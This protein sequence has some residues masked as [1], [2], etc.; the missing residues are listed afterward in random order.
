MKLLLVDKDHDLIEMLAGWLKTLGYEVSYAYTGERA[1]IEWA[2]HQPDLVILDTTLKD[3]DALAMC[4][5]MRSRYDALLLVMTDGKDTQ[6]EIHS[7]ESG[8]D[9]YLRKPFSPAQFL[10]HVHA[11][12][13]RVNFMHVQRPSSTITIGPI[14]IDS[15]HNQVI[16]YDK[17]TRLTPTESKLLHLL[18][19]NAN[20]VCTASHIVSHVWGFNGAGDSALIKAHIRHLR[21]KIEP[22]PGNPCY[23]QTVPSLGYMLV[24]RAG[25]EHDAREVAQPLSAISV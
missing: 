13:R 10:A 6:D 19:V 17:T 15:L 12:S 18:A 5:E 25:E 22:D 7:L 24:P 23:I 1:K 20:Q 8:A 4:R 9:D 3:V 16:I 2:R 21:Q 11:V 14:R